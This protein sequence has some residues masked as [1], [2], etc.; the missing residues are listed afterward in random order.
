MRATGSATVMR[1]NVW[2]LSAMLLA[3]GI[4]A[5]DRAAPVRSA[6]GSDRLWEVLYQDNDFRIS[7]DTAAIRPQRDGSYLVW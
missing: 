2:R 4:T 6:A 5:C 3:T 1:L 7:L